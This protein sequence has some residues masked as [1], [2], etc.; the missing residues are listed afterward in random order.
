MFSRERSGGG[1]HPVGVIG[2][3]VIGSHRTCSPTT[4]FDFNAIAY[5]QLIY[6]S[7][8]SV[9]HNRILLQ[10]MTAPE[11]RESTVEQMLLLLNRL[12]L[13]RLVHAHFNRD[14][15]TSRESAIECV[16]AWV[17]RQAS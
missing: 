2:D 4:I 5:A 7:I 6:T 12:V 8:D 9:I 17:A 16:C 1:A 13:N 10:L 11:Q 15:G 3:G 14:D